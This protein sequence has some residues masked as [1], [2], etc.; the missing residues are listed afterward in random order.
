MPKLKKRG[1]P[2]SPEWVDTATAIASLGIC[3]DHLIHLKD[4]GILKQ[5]IHWRDIRRKD[6]YRA[7]YRWHLERC[8][9]VLDIP[10]EKRG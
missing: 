1:R 10:P 4:D 3:R 8:N 7:T 2:L 9:Q 5:N 6:A